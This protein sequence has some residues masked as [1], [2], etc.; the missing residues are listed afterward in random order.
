MKKIVVFVAG[1]LLI[2][3]F[4]VTNRVEKLIQKEIKSVFSIE[5]YTK[6]TISV[7]KE[8]NETLPIKISEENF[9]KIV[10]NKELKGYYFISK[11]FGKTDYFDFIVIFNKDLIVTKIKVLV[12]REDHGGEIGSRRWLKQF[13]GLKTDKKI[14]YQDDITAISGAT[15]SAKSITNQV[16]K[17]LKTV[18][19]LHQQKQL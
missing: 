3:S 16:N 11:G 13:I 9:F 7:S 2:S 1:F 6:E 5:T 17:I 15:L 14:N 10:S 8:I 18:H 4:T 12:Y 19:I